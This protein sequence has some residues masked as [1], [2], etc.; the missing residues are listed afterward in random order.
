MAVITFHVSH[1][2]ILLCTPNPVGTQN[3]QFWYHFLKAARA[4]AR[5]IPGEAGAASA[6]LFFYSSP[7]LS[8]E[9][10]LDPKE[11][12]VIYLSLTP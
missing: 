3:A 8:L 9:S 6:K 11:L 12:N 1:T 4:S 5:R 7:L 2:A 10:A